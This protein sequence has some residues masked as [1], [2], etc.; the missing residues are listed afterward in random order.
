[1]LQI[2]VLHQSLKPF[3]V[4]G[5]IK[6]CRWWSVLELRRL[7]DFNLDKETLVVALGGQAWYYRC[8]DC[9]RCL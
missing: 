6:Q 3:V 4:K 5:S 9:V 7:P 2:P 1:M 8:V